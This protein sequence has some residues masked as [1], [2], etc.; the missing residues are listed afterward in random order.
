MK[1][2]VLAEHREASERLCAGARLAGGEVV[3]IAIGQNAALTGVADKVV[4]L[5]VPQGAVADDAAET[6]IA[7][8]EDLQPTRAFVEPTRHLKVV[9]GKL[10]A[11]LG[12]AVVTDVIDLHGDVAESRYFGG[13]AHRKLSAKSVPLYTISG[14]VFADA[15]ASGTDVI[16]E[17]AWIAPAHP[18]TL[19]DARVIEKTG[20]D[21]DK[22][23][24]IVG[25]GRGFAEEGQL[26]MARELCDELGAGLGCTRPLTEGL[27]WLPV[28]TYIGVS[29]LMLAPKTYV[30]IGI[31]GQ[32]QHMVGCNR[33]GTFFA[34]NKDK[35]A[36]VFKQ[37]DYGLVGD[38][39]TVLPALIAAMRG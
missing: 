3:L 1:T 35:N 8:F 10:A 14:Q 23:D 26:A 18:L 25:V 7:L 39:A 5:T 11:H 2:V 24:V 17:A 33:A 4:R 37:C 29:G 34:I 15:E 27:D 21:L 6:V 38:I 12:T 30:A 16:E 20:V 13:L 9:A 31:S 19:V 22:A 32:I 28:E 36:P